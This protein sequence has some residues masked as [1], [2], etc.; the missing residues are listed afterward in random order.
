MAK[1]GLWLLVL[2]K[3]QAFIPTMAKTEAGFYMGIEPVAVVDVSDRRGVEDAL[4]CTVCRGNPIVPTPTRDTFPE[5]VVLK[6]AKVKSLSTF[7]RSSE[8]WQLAKHHDAYTL[9]PCRPGKH[10]GS[11]EDPDRTETIPAEMTL[12]AVVHRLVARAVDSLKR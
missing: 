3:G 7:E 10:G 8:T 5:D 9:A 11:E 2:R 4:L 12:V 6:H 1:D